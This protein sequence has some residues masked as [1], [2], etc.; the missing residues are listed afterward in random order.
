M[1]RTERIRVLQSAKHDAAS[2][3][4]VYW[5]CRDQRAQDNWALTYAAQTARAAG[6]GL[7]VMFCLRKQFTHATARL[8]DFMLAGL[9]EVEEE[10]RKKHIPFVVAVGNPAVEVLKLTGKIGA[11]MLVADMMPLHHV[12][13]WKQEIAARIRIPFIE[14]DAHNIVPVW[15][16]SQKQE[17]GAYTLRPKLHRL[18]P[19]FLEGTLPRL[20]E[21]L[22]RNIRGYAP[23]GWKRVRASTLVDESVPAVAGVVSGTRAARHVLNQFISDR[24]AGYDADRNNPTL[25][26]QSG[27]SP[28]LHFGQLSAERVV[29]EVLKVADVSVS[30]AL[31]EHKNGA[32]GLRGS[33]PAFIE[34][35][36]VRR[37][38]SDNF[39]F[40][41]PHYD[42]V[43]GFPEWARKSL[44]AHKDDS[45]GH[46]YTLA[47]LEQGR[48][49]D[50]L[51]N[52]AQLQMVQQ[53]KMHG[54]MR[55][56]WA[57]KI[58][59]WS[60]TP[61]TAMRHAIY[62]NDRYSLDGRDPNGYA[63]IAWSVGGVHDR[64]W[65][66]RPIFG[67]IRYMS[68]GGAKSKFDI[69]AYIANVTKG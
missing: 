8:V 48:T 15:H 5:M 45:R 61:Q 4:V 2:G 1:V 56:Y 29:R 57:K 51:W 34:E 10:L 37:E 28:Y 59:E 23:V 36:V 26:G 33:V 58:L 40:Y 12:Q 55:M 16:A 17:F 25:Q 53:G 30:A 35:L 24:L 65:F 31:H 66:E 60:A 19:Q 47:E 7:V 22:E 3:P 41:N 38:L 64:A 68:Y 27:L 20:P 49:Q 67:K 14:V 32:A 6:V 9:V 43:K 11:S 18:V 44:D 42:S 50:E 46:V 52:A 54:Y 63:G 39:C 62:L 13:S 69:K 21:F